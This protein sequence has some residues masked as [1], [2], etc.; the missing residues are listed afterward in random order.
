MTVT[1]VFKKRS[2]TLAQKRQHLTPA[3]RRRPTTFVAI[4]AEGWKYPATFP[5][6]CD[7][8]AHCHYQLKG[9]LPWLVKL[10]PKTPPNRSRI[11]RSA[12]WRP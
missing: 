3:Y 4:F 8:I 11:K 10:L 7:S 6:P 12:N 9:N 2:R 5:G 1:S